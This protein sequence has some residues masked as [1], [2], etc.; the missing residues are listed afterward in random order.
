MLNASGR[1][2]Y[3]P[4]TAPMCKKNIIIRMPYSKSEKRKR[5]LYNA[6]LLSKTMTVIL[7]LNPYVKVLQKEPLQVELENCNVFFRHKAG[8]YFDQ[9]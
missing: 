4:I 5:A 7:E 9:L 6:L 1:E 8:D 3:F 2:E